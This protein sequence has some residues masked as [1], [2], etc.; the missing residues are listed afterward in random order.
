MKHRN[1]P[2]PR[3]RAKRTERSELPLARTRLTEHLL[4]PHDLDSVIEWVQELW[5]LR[6]RLTSEGRRERAAEIGAG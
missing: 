5:A 1:R 4:G 3:S 6:H 2:T